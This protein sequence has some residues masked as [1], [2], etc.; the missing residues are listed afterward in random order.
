M[1]WFFAV[2][3]TLTGLIGASSVLLFSSG[4]KQLSRQTTGDVEVIHSKVH[5]AG[6]EQK[7]LG[8]VAPGEHV[9]T[10]GTGRARLHLVEGITALLDVSTEVAIDV[11]RLQ[12]YSGKLFIDSPEGRKITLNTGELTAQLAAS[13]TAIEFLPQEHRV[14]LYCAQGEVMVTMK[15]QSQRVESG[16]TLRWDNGKFTVEPE[17]AF[18]DWTQGLAVP[19][20]T[21]KLSRSSLPEI[22]VYNEQGEPEALLTT[23]SQ[24]VQV[25]LDGELAT[26]KTVTR[27]YNGNDHDVKP[28]LRVAI[29]PKAQLN[30]VSY[31]QLPKDMV[32]EATLA[33]CDADLST[34]P[35]VARVEWGGNGWLTGRLPTVASGNSLELTLE[36]SLWQ[37]VES[38]IVTYRHSFAKGI[39]APQIG[40]LSVRVDA[41]SARSP[42]LEANRGVTRTGDVLFWHAADVRPSDDWVTRYVPA[43]IKT[44][45]A[46]AYVEPGRSAEDDYVMVRFESPTRP[47]KPVRVA[48]VIDISASIGGTG[49]ELGRNLVEALLGNLSEKDSAIVVVTDEEQRTLMAERPA[50]ITKE[51]RKQLQLELSKLRPGGASDIG[52]ALEYA[53]DKLDGSADAGHFQNAVVYLGDGKPTLGALTSEQLR[54]R[55]ARRTSGMPKLSAVAL[56]RTADVWQLAK[57][58]A[59]AGE[60]HAVS[61]R[62]EAAVVAS[63][64]VASLQEPS[65]SDL[66]IELGPELDRIYPRV[67]QSVDAGSTV[68]AYG[69]LRGTLPKTIKVTYFDEGRPKTEDMPLRKVSVPSLADISRRWAEQRLFELVGTKDGLKPAL[70][71]AKDHHLL[72]PWSTW[73]FAEPN[74]DRRFTCTSYESRI[75]ELS[76][77][78]DTPYAARIAPERPIGS[79]WLEPKARYDEQQS[80]IDAVRLN[81]KAVILRSLPAINNCLNV[82]FGVT[83]A[84]PSKIDY[85]LRIQPSGAAEGV[86]VTASHGEPVDNP[87]LRCVE[88][89][90]RKETYL[91]GEQLVTV[92]GT[93][94]LLESPRVK[95]SICS[96]ASRLPLELRKSVWVSRVGSPINLYINALNSCELPTWTDRRKMLEGLIERETT[97][98]PRINFSKALRAHGFTDAATH[99]EHSTLERLGNLEEL[100]SARRLMQSDEPNI[101]ALL[102]TRLKKATTD[103]ARLLTVRE[104][105]RL[106]PHSPL[107]RR[108][109][110]L[111]LEELHQV[112]ELLRTTDE[113]RQDPFADAGLITSAAAALHR[114]GEERPSRRAFAELFERA[115]FDPWVL[116]FAGDHLRLAG[117][118]D[119]AVLA[120]ES[121]SAQHPNES[122][123][124]LRLGLAQANAGRIDIASRLLERAAQIGGRGDDER[125]NELSA[126]VKAVILAQARDQAKLPQERDELTRRLAET[127]LPETFAIVLLELGE[128]LEE[129]VEVMVYRGRQ[130]PAESPELYATPLGLYGLSL[131]P[132]I[133][134]LRVVMHRRLI[135]K[136]GRSLKVKLHLLRLGSNL[137]ERTLVTKE[138]AFEKNSENAEVTL[139]TENRP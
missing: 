68:T 25:T 38:G 69:R 4:K 54:G 83:S 128:R 57:L 46:R 127:A 45:E 2:A 47:V 58:V 113:I 43:V 119:E 81:T 121:L 71:L 27:Y 98:E 92:T 18:D 63:K 21:Q 93:L 116:A 60:I 6:Q 133:P 59:S 96:V 79:G 37:D 139:S 123:N 22:W 26:T 85:S 30:R 16:E 97:I 74:S 34:Q 66:R 80:L 75:V 10:E 42:W 102:V 5:V 19:W 3:V 117:L 82:R 39:D 86:Q 115:P 94:E 28:R 65:Y 35:G 108:L 56:G 103:D 122:S 126:Y 77:L 73:V 107:G 72:T 124:F 109:L 53:A 40:E 88:R 13:K 118:Y 106:A 84:L 41:N 101:D 55:L 48:L 70:M 49:L 112:P 1:V 36:Y 100:E 95:R 14:T 8:R 135:T 104:A 136:L 78:N 91:G 87:F 138:F 31:Q 129:P 99:V 67:G 111:L 105:L 131:E 20:Q 62:A 44:K 64:L 32:H 90:I 76:T 120:Y 17:K 130:G 51:W 15:G 9:V 61:E 23:T 134:E 29:P 125:L 110:L 132:G 24:V 33:L 89:V 50:T 11:G 52:R 12:L 137:L 114:L 7:G